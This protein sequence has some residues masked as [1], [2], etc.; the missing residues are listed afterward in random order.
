MGCVEPKVVYQPLGESPDG[1]LRCAVGGVRHVASERGPEAVDAAGVDDMSFLTCQQ[2]GQESPAHE[3]DA[4][5]TDVEG[6]LPLLLGTRDK[7]AA[8][9]NARIVEQQIDVC[10]AVL[11]FNFASED[12]HLIRHRHIAHVA[13]DPDARSRLSAAQ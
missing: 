1:E 5:P 11:G 7:A 6:P 8:T 4:V 10:N 3:I 12:V 9:P 2:H 13:G